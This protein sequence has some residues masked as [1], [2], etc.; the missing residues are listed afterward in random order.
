MMRMEGRM[1]TIVKM[2]ESL[3]DR[4]QHKESNSSSTSLL[5][6]LVPSGL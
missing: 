1:D 5:D 2:L 4:L 3:T 6:L